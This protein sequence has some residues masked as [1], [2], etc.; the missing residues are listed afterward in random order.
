MKKNQDKDPRVYKNCR[1]EE[2]GKA[3]EWYIHSDAPPVCRECY[4]D[5]IYN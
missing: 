5:Y 4:K 2:C 3:K 1:L